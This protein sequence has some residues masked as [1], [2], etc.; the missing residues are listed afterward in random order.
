[1]KFWD[2][3][4]IVPL[5]LAEPATKAVQALAAKDGAMLVWWAGA[6]TC[7]AIGEQRWLAHAQRLR[8]TTLS[9]RR[10]V[11]FALEVVLSAN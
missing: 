1:M 5:I 4:A 9:R 7:L 11:G 10:P 3:S 8:L 2:A 6:A